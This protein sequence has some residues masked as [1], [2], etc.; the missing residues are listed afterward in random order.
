ML[1]DGR[2]QEPERAAVGEAAR[3]PHAA[4][5]SDSRRAG[6]GVVLRRG[7]AARQNGAE[8]GGLRA[9]DHL[10][11]ALRLPQAALDGA[12]R[13]L[14]HGRADP[15]PHDQGARHQ[16][17]GDEE[18]CAVRAEQR[19][20]ELELRALRGVLRGAPQ[21]VLPLP[22]QVPRLHLAREEAAA[23]GRLV[24]RE[25]ARV[26][27]AGE[28]RGVCRVARARAGARA[29]CCPVESVGLGMPAAQ[30]V[31]CGGGRER[32]QRV[33]AGLHHKVAGPDEQRRVC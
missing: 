22:P 16:A 17:G 19:E 33:E 23:E 6:G 26:A 10:L 30:P 9:G 21:R 3:G 11:L 31:V 20:D 14:P 4:G 15:P 25:L 18:Y 2:H 12:A 7:A 13:A 8:A 28:Q 27:A 1:P 29:L 5:G 32:V 24:G